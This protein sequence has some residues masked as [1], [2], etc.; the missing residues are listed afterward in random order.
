MKSAETTLL[1]L[2]VA[3]IVLAVLGLFLAVWIHK[4]ALKT[5][6]CLGISFWQNNL[7]VLALI[8]QFYFALHLISALSTFDLFGSHTHALS[9]SPVSAFSLIAVSVVNLIQ[10]NARILWGIVI[11]VGSIIAGYHD[12]GAHT[13]NIHVFLF[14]TSFVFV[15]VYSIFYSV[16]KG[17][18]ETGFGFI[19]CAFSSFFLLDASRVA[20]KVHTL[21]GISISADL[22][23]VAGLL[24]VL[25][26]TAYSLKI[27][28]HSILILLFV[29]TLF[30]ALCYSPG[31]IVII[32][33][34]G[35]FVSVF[36]GSEQKF[37]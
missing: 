32:C 28:K 2:A 16:P 7:L 36:L 10:R 37:G 22:V 30:L 34:A 13:R 4:R 3:S 25:A 19:M 35:L 33:L 5:S 24:I 20:R 14:L 17:I 6:F 29:P 9:M 23:I 15:G 8:Y 1:L 26:W 31:P 18:S 21:L 11:L 12:F 27:I